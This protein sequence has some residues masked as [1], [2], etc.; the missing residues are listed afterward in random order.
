MVRDGVGPLP[1]GQVVL[2][3]H[4][5]AGDRDAWPGDDRARPLDDRGRRQARA[6]ADLLA[7][8]GVTRLVSSPALRCV[9]T[10]APLSAAL[11]VD[12]EQRD[13]L[14]EDAP[15]EAL[16]RLLEEVAH[17]PAA[18]CLHGDVFPDLL[19]GRTS[20]KGGAWVVRVAGDGVE[21]VAYHPPVKAPSSG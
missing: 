9:E 7:G 1:P 11:A 6:I 4:A 13:E 18:L 2:V 10:L 15:R 8:A 17:R 21:P 12:I 14:A 20:K 16:R 3:R 19:D 5:R